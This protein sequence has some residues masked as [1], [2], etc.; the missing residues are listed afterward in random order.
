MLRE[1]MTWLLCTIV[2]ALLFWYVLLPAFDAECS[3]QDAKTKAFLEQS[4]PGYSDKL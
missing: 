3:N 4:K 2:A 1:F